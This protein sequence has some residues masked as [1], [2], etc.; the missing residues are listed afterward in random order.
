[1]GSLVFISSIAH[2]LLA[3]LKV[4]SGTC[5]MKWELPTLFPGEYVT[6]IVGTCAPFLTPLIKRYLFLASTGEYSSR[7]I[8]G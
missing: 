3:V 6:R 8:N 2:W 7:L 5:H 4:L 1:M